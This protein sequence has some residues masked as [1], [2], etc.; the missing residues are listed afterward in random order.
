MPLL[1][2]DEILNAEGGEYKRADL[3]G[4]YAAVACSALKLTL[5]QTLGLNTA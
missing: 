5:E 3:E 4:L 1:R 2:L